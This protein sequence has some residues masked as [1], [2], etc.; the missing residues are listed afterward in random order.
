M[1][2]RNRAHVVSKDDINRLEDKIK[3]LEA[4]IFNAKKKGE[5]K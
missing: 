2:D 4:N 1:L 3:D 5:E